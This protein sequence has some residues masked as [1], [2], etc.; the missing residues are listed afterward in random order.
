MDQD[1]AQALLG[2]RRYFAKRTISAGS[3]TSIKKLARGYRIAAGVRP[4]KLARPRR[5]KYELH[6]TKG[7][8][9]A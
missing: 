8:V 4:F 6:P 1:K 2:A 9:L 3:A 7:W 5:G